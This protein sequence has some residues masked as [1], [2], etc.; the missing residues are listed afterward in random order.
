MDNWLL[1]AP[2][3]LIIFNRPETTARV[4]V[5]IRKAKP[6]KL[7]VVADGPRS[8]RP[9]EADKCAAARAVIEQ[10]DWDCELFTDYANTNMGCRQR[11]SSGIDWIFDTVEEAIILEDDCLPHPTFFRFCDELLERYRDDKRIMAISG[12]NF[13][14]GRTWTNYSYYFS[15]YNHI[16][17]WATWR[18][19][20]QYYDVTMKLWPEIR[21]KGWLN[22]ILSNAGAAKFWSEN[23]QMIYAGQERRADTW[24]AQWTFTCWIQNGLTILP[25]VNLVS[26]IGFNLEATHTFNHWSRVANMPIAAM[27]FPLQHPPYMIREAQADDFTRNILFKS[28]FFTRTIK[29]IVRK[30][31]AYRRNQCL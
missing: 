19:A 16:W 11:V 18:R 20:W 15:R 1:K 2:V 31:L 17:G 13:Q 7:L 9:N 25:T 10:V 24:D 30:I 5:E 4:F 23:F 27:V 8:D 28:N 21:S 26:N 6:A 14:F 12:D 3:A 29:R 22:D